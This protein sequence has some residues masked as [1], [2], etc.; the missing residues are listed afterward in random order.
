MYVSSKQNKQMKREHQLQWRGAPG[1][2][3]APG[4][5]LAQ[6]TPTSAPAQRKNKET[7]GFRLKSSQVDKLAAQKV[8]LG[9]P[10]IEA[11]KVAS[12]EYRQRQLQGNSLARGSSTNAAA[13][14]AAY[15][16]TLPADCPKLT[17]ARIRVHVERGWAGKSP[18]RHGPSRVVPDCV[19]ALV[20]SHTSMSQLNGDELKPKAVKR[21]MI[22]LVEGTE[23]ASKLPSKQQRAKFLKRLRTHGGMV[24]MTKIV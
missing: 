24:T 10:L 21:N 23:F 4:S 1:T 18:P 5:G 3:L 9:R 13:I 16:A 7:S 11:L 15:N 8:A 6:A 22:A 14:V 17:G 12:A 2:Y 19:V 20:A